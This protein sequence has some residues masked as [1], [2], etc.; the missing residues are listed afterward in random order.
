MLL[1]KRS[2]NVAI[3]VEAFLKISA[4]VLHFKLPVGIN[5]DFEMLR[6]FIGRLFVGNAFL[7]HDFKVEPV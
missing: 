4:V 6:A 5:I 2:S 7:R 1:V 3:S